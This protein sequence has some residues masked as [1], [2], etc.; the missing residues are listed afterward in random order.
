MPV[1]LFHKERVTFRVRGNETY[2]RFRGL[3]SAE[4]SEHFSYCISRQPEQADALAEMEANQIVEGLCQR[5]RWI[6]LVV[7]IGANNYHGQ[8]RY[9]TRQVDEQRESSLVCPLEIVE[10]QDHRSV[11]C[12]AREE[13]YNGVE[14]DSARLLRRNFE[15]RRYIRRHLPQLRHQPGQL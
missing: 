3:T 1:Q 2:Q 12:R 10:H 5:F 14:Q 9:R 4:R 11:S 6:E 7:A 13:F 15:R 8:L